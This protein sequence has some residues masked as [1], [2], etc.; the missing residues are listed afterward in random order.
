[1]LVQ[2]GIGYSIIYIGYST[3]IG[4]IHTTHR[5]PKTVAYNSFS[6]F[7][8]FTCLHTSFSVQRDHTLWVG[9]TVT[10]LTHASRSNFMF[11]KFTLVLIFLRFTFIQIQ[12]VQFHQIE[13]NF[14]RPIHFASNTRTSYFTLYFFI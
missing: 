11:H 7:I 2:I 5:L 10:I 4:S 6:R 3:I 14:Q 9:L 13:H 8:Y 12:V 1:M